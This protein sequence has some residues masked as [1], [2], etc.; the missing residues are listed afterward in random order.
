[1]VDEIAKT[2][3]IAAMAPSASVQ[4][5]FIGALRMIGSADSAGRPMKLRDDDINS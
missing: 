2:K 5:V 4:R 1:L 3:P